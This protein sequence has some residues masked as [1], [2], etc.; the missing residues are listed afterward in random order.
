MLV[1]GSVTPNF[2]KRRDILTKQ[3]PPTSGAKIRFNAFAS[4]NL[5]GPAEAF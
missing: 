1:S 3:Q 2:R 4:L 5:L